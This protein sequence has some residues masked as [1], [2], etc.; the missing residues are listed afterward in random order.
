MRFLHRH[1]KWEKEKEVA[2]IILD[3]FLLAFSFHIVGMNGSK[4]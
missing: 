2:R 4:Q 1:D 3:N